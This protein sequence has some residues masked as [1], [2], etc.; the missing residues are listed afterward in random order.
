MT[1]AG[2]NVAGFPRSDGRIPCSPAPHS[3]FRGQGIAIQVFAVQRGIATGWGWKATIPC[4]Q[5]ILPPALPSRGPSRYVRLA[6]RTES[7]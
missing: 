6:T 7:R 5:G 1:I 4:E 3:L 2:C